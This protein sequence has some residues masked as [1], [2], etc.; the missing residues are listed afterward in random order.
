MT[1]FETP[2]TAPAEHLWR[3]IDT[4]NNSEHHPAISFRSEGVREGQLTFIYGDRPPK[5]TL[6]P[7][8]LSSLE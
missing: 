5:T 8:S 4:I 3:R 6:S 1:L 7:E 2:S